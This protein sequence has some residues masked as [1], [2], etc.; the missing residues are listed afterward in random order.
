MKDQ[1]RQVQ[2]ERHSSDGTGRLV[3]G[4][5][6]VF[7]KPSWASLQWLLNICFDPVLKSSRSAGSGRDPLRTSTGKI[8]TRH[9][10]SCKRGG[11]KES[12]KTKTVF[13]Y[14][15]EI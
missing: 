15:A 10:R 12:F 1:L 14:L 2:C 13:C 11:Y 8:R 5:V 4:D 6:R 9:I 3:R 7:S